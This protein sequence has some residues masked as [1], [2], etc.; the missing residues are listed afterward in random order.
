M[1][2]LYLQNID[3]PGLFFI[4]KKLTGIKNYG[5]WKRS[6]TI[7]LS[8]KNKLG[9]INGSFLKPKIDSPLRAQW[10]RVNDIDISWI[11]N[12]ISEEI[13]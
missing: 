3:H 9:L 10:D 4:T 12:T 5:P 13:N 6:M 1:H 7:A 2:P 8:A 11:L